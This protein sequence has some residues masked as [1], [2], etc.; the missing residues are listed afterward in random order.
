MAGGGAGREQSDGLVLT[1]VGQTEPIVLSAPGGGQVRQPGQQQ[2]S[3]V[4]RQSGSKVGSKVGI[5]LNNND[6]RH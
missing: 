4:R 1:A 2:N 6:D 3:L 5:Q